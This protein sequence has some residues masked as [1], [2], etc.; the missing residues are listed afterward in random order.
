LETNS[1]G[2]NGNRLTSFTKIFYYDWRDLQDQEDSTKIQPKF[3]FR[4]LDFQLVIPDLKPGMKLSPV[5]VDVMFQVVNILDGLN[6]LFHIQYLKMIYLVNLAG[7]YMDVVLALSLE[8]YDSRL[9]WKLS[10][11]MN[12]RERPVKSEDIWTPKIGLSNQIYTKFYSHDWEINRKASVRYNGKITILIKFYKIFKIKKSGKVRQY[13]L[14]RADVNFKTSSQL[15]PY[16]TQNTTLM[17][18]SLDHGN[19]EVQ[20]TT[21]ALD[22]LNE[23]SEEWNHEEWIKSNNLS[24]IQVRF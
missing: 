24:H 20:L 16:D 7:E 18:Q 1:A 8:W 17:I 14:F 22:S 3:N 19:N 10:N 2:K 23:K 13:R 15:Y 11:E 9:K 12:M 4:Y 21:K 5:T 6:F